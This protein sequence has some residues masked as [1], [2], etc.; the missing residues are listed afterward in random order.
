VSGYDDDDDEPGERG[1]HNKVP[2]WQW[3][4]LVGVILWMGYFV[5]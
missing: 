2:L 1:S 3:G 5:I 4:I